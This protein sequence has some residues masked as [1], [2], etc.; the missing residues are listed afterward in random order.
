MPENEYRLTQTEAESVALRLRLIRTD[1]VADAEAIN[2]VVR[3]LFHAKTI[4]ITPR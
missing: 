1:S 2:S 3:A 4:V